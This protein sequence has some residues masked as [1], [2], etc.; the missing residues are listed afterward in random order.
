MDII[1]DA[2][3]EYNSNIWIKASD[4]DENYFP[5]AIQVIPTRDYKV[6]IYFD[7]G[8]I[9][10]FDASTLIKGGVFKVLQDEEL[11]ISSCTVLNNTLAWDIT[12]N[13][14]EEDCL[15]LDPLQLY[16]SC[17]EVEEP[18]WLFSSNIEL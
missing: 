10:L 12:G 4:L 18:T 3:L 11:F 9:K 5:E 7:D 17:P 14:S 15:D 8:R 6:Y 1:K 16:N 13:Y 2:Q